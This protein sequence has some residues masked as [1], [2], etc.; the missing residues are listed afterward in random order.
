MDEGTLFLS[1]MYKEEKVLKEAL[2]H[3]E[4]DIGTVFFKIKDYDFNFTDYYEKE[5]GSGLKKTIYV[6]DGRIKKDE[7]VEIKVLCGQIELDF[8]DEISGK[9]SIN[10]DPGYFNEMEVVLA[11]FKGKEFKEDL[12][13]GI[14][15]HK[16]LEFEDGKAKEFF[17]TFEDFKSKDVQDFFINM[18]VLYS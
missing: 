16:V 1:I 10:I 4:R 8:A 14:F 6:F 15:A 2:N 17:H 5:F 12:G 13:D 9:R 3:I 7:L 11:S 18:S